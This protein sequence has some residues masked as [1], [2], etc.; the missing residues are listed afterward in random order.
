MESRGDIHGRGGQL[1][2]HNKG[3]RAEATAVCVSTKVKYA[4]RVPR[5][6][7]AGKTQF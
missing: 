6:Q 7:A 3:S 5:R 4:A 1:P 2:A